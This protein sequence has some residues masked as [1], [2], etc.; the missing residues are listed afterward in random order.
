MKL[1]DKIIYSSNSL[2]TSIDIVN[3]SNAVMPYPVSMAGYFSRF[4]ICPLQMGEE[5]NKGTIGI[6][7]PREKIDEP[8]I[9]ILCQDI[10]A[11]VTLNGAQI[12]TF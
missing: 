4:G 3:S 6:Y 10:Q 12:S 11:Q 7:I 5:Y 8:H 2:L 9:Q 1:N